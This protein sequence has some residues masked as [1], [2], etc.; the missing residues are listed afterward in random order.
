M[1]FKYDDESLVIS[2]TIRTDERPVP[3]SIKQHDPDE[4]EQDEDIFPELQYLTVDNVA[5]YQQTQQYANIRQKQIH[6]IIKPSH[7]NINVRVQR[8]F[9]SDS[10]TDQPSDNTIKNLLDNPATIDAG[11]MMMSGDN[12]VS[13]AEQKK[14]ELELAALEMDEQ[15][16]QDIEDIDNDM[17]VGEEDTE[18]DFEKHLD[19]LSGTPN[20]TELYPDDTERDIAI[21]KYLQKAPEVDKKSV[22]PDAIILPVYGEL[23]EYSKMLNV[24]RNVISATLRHLGI[25][26]HNI[27]TQEAGQKLVEHLRPN[28]E[29]ILEHIVDEI[30]PRIPYNKQSADYYKL[31]KRKP[32][33]CILGHVDHGKTTLLDYL[34]HSHVADHEAGGITQSIGA[35]PINM[36]EYAKGN[37]TPHY[38]EI[39]VFDTPGHAA[40]TGM[41]QRGAHVVDLAILVIDACDGVKPQTKESLALSSLLYVCFICVVCIDFVM[42]CLNQDNKKRE[43]TIFSGY[44]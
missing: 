6:N 32:V 35:F 10:R 3:R 42:L 31:S 22:P 16:E 34:R 30:Q 44:K 25:Y 28:T 7:S 27:I 36:K 40:F 2:P 12:S 18:F 29:V 41:R 39:V 1:P 33:L 19:E 20:F 21:D 38:D 15:D 13:N 17:L 37:F 5:K 43:N 23:K 24:E 9:S 14:K 11:D 8:L 4:T 26:T